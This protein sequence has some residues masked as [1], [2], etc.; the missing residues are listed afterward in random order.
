MAHRG[1]QARD[2]I[3]ATAGGL[4]HSDAESEPR[5][6]SVPQLMAAWDP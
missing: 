6:Q 2:P 5:L 3:A 1:S 4:H